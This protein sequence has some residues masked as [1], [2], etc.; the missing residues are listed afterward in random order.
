MPRTSIENVTARATVFTLAAKIN[1]ALVNERQ[2]K[3]AGRFGA[4]TYDSDGS[5]NDSSDDDESDSD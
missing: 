2:H 4:N 5:D 1:A 3:A